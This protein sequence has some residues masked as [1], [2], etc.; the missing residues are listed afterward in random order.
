VTNDWG[1]DLLTIREQ[2]GKTLFCPRRLVLPS[3]HL[4]SPQVANSLR[5]SRSLSKRSSFEETAHSITHPST[6]R[7]SHPYGLRPILLYPLLVYPSLIFFNL[8]LRMTWS[9]KLSSHLY[10]DAYG[11]TAV[12]CLEMAELIRRWMWV[13]IR[14]EWEV[15]RKLQ[16]GE[17]LSPKDGRKDS[18]EFELLDA[19]QEER[20]RDAAEMDLIDEETL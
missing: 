1:L 4:E 17:S 3:L 10:V 19:A 14:V 12:F 8:I 11:S 13:F 20:K 18:E 6:L 9:I 15:V 16:V 2:K 5:H 7:R